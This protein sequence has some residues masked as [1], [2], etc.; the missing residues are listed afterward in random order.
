MHLS[1]ALLISNM[2]ILLFDDVHAR[3]YWV[4]W[5][6]RLLM[7]ALLFPLLSS[8]TRSPPSVLKI[9]IMW[10]LTEAD[11]IR[12]P[13]LFTAIAPI[14]VESCAKI[15]KSML[16][17]TT[18]QQQEMSVSKWLNKILTKI[19]H[20]EMTFLQC[21]QTNYLGRRLFS[22]WNSDKTKRIRIRLNLF[23]ELERNKVEDEC[24]L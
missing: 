4:G 15:C 19:E 10:P 23:N 3:I 5:K 12:V 7:S 18:K 14:S 24:L 20:F 17:S 8:W 9:L 21:W 11:A 2:W 6:T 13:S 16:L 22:R 1:T